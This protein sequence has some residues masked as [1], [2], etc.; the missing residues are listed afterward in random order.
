MLYKEN[1]NNDVIN[2]NDI[3]NGKYTITIS[4]DFSLPEFYVNFIQDLE[5]KYEIQINDR[6]MAILGLKS[7]MY[8][9]E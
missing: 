6:E 2:I 1:K 4:Y 5:K 9:E 7:G 8:E 3:K